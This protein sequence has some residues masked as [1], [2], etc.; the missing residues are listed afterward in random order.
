MLR[1]KKRN[2]ILVGESELKAAI[3]EVI[4][5]IENKELGDGAFANVNVIHLDKSQIPASCEAE[6]VGGFD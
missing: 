5:K 1:T 2:P 4:K 6:G 3:K